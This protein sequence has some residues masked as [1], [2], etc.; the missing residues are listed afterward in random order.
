MGRAFTNLF[1]DNCK[2]RVSVFD[3]GTRRAAIIGLD[4]LVVPRTVVLEARMQIQK[5]C[6]ISGDAVLICASHSHSSGPVGMAV[7]R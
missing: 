2:V 6:G 7:A 3:D 4:A 5:A 1:T